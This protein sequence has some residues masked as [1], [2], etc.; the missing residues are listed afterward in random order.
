MDAAVVALSAER[1]C[2]HDAVAGFQ[3]LARDIELAPC[4]QFDDLGKRFMPLDVRQ[5][6]FKVESA[7]VLVYIGPADSR[8]Q[9]LR[10]YAVGSQR[11]NRDILYDIGLTVLDQ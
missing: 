10:Y 3:G 7:V 11:R 4:A 1:V 9:Y 6:G 5:R 8:Q 2:P